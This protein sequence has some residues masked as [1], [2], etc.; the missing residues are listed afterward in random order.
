MSDELET[1]ANAQVGTVKQW[2][3]PRLVSLLFCDSCEVRDDDKTDVRGIFDRIYVHPEI[4]LTP[5]FTLFLRT[6]ETIDGLMRV[7]CLA[8][9][10][11]IPTMITF[12]RVP[13]EEYTQNLPANYQSIV[14]MNPFY[15][16]TEGIYWFDV[17]F[18]GNSLGGA[19]LV[20]EFRE[21]EDKSGGTDTYV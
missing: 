12:E 3:Q 6:A 11:Q 18:E 16:Y 17:L 15:V 2:Q 14:H 13:K 10:G 20:I 8:P 5:P 19:A 21:T 1:S 4:R 9:N 7:H